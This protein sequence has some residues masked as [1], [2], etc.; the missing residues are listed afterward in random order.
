LQRINIFDFIANGLNPFYGKILN[1]S[2][3]RSKLIRFFFVKRS[4]RKM[5]DP[6]TTTIEDMRKKSLKIS[7]LIKLPKDASIKEVTVNGVNAEWCKAGTVPDDSENIL[8]YF[9]PGAFCLG[10]NNIH[11]DFALKISKANNLKVFAVKYRLAPENKYP[12][13]N[14]DCLTTYLYLLQNGIKPE[15]II[16]GGASAGAGLALTILLSLKDLGEPM[17]RAAFFIS[18]F[19]DLKNFDGES[20]TTNELS[21]PLTYKKGL[22]KFSELFTGGQ[23]IEPTIDKDLS[24]LPDLFIQVG[25][26]EVLLSNTNLII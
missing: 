12:A 18:I 6:Y 8:L 25:K 15:N 9:H 1:M 22:E 13:A 16:I 7:K 21:D 19:A 4:M 26:D 17:P 14:E 24:G 11:R 23:R 5:Y 10:Y 3:I 2:S 20:Y